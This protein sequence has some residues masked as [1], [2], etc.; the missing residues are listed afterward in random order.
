MKESFKIVL[1]GL[2]VVLF[3]VFMLIPQGSN[4]DL[5][6]DSV[7]SATFSEYS[8]PPDALISDSARN[9]CSRL[10]VE[11]S[12]LR[13]ESLF[14]INNLK[15]WT[16][17][18]QTDDLNSGAR[19]EID[20]RGDTSFLIPSDVEIVTGLVFRPE[21]L[22]VGIEN[23]FSADITVNNMIEIIA[24]L[25]GE[26]KQGRFP[27]VKIGC[28]R[29]LNGGGFSPDRVLDGNSVT[30][31]SLVEPVSNKFFGIG[32]ANNQL[33]SRLFLVSLF[34]VLLIALTRREQNS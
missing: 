10:M 11:G 17:V 13:I 34:L 24:Q 9:L 5:S 14:T 27:N 25:N 20:Q 1:P 4:V 18:F 26:L 31:I 2:L 3:L 6:Q 29:T 23:R 22:R 19:L 16:N 12:T 30:Q 7:T 8:N 28:N 21:T 33:L 32:L 15:D